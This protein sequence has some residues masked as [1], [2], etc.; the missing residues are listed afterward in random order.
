MNSH[1]QV[2][3]FH[4]DLYKLLLENKLYLVDSFEP[5]NAGILSSNSFFNGRQYTVSQKK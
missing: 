5:L 1:G 3:D 4:W 2:I